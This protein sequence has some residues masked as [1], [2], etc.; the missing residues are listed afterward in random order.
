[1]TVS[2]A[3]GTDQPH[4]AH[5]RRWRM[6]WRIGVLIVDPVEDAVGV[7]SVGCASFLVANVKTVR[8]VLRFADSH[9]YR[10]FP[11]NNGIL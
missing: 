3:L 9:E 8:T 1:V 5:A 11:V 4:V 7:L 2:Q 10:N 6:P